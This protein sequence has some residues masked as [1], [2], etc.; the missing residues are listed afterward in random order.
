VAKD[1]K[2]V[3]FQLGVIDKAAYERT[4]A[5]GLEVVMDRCPAIELNALRWL[6]LGEQFKSAGRNGRDTGAVQQ[7]PAACRTKNIRRSLVPQSSVWCVERTFPA[8]HDRS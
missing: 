6:R 2:A 4:R 5:A 3:W 7:D 8:R 1:A